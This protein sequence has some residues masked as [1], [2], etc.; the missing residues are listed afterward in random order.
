MNF[1]TNRK[2]F[3]PNFNPKCFANTFNSTKLSKFFEIH[4]MLKI[5]ELI[6]LKNQL[7]S[8]LF[9]EVLYGIFR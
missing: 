6:M 7:S 5:K 8:T 1:N 3:T 9:L 4:P 2:F